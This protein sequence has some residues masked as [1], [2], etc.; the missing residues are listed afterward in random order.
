MR[1]YSHK[2][3]SNENVQPQMQRHSHKLV[4]RQSGIKR[5]RTGANAMK[6]IQIAAAQMPAQ[7]VAQTPVQQAAH[8]SAQEAAQTPAQQ[9]DHADPSN[10]MPDAPHIAQQVSKKTTKRSTSNYSQCCKNSCIQC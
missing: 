2:P 10:A 4:V 8:S 7:Q 6:H 3:E 1:R 5:T 9:A